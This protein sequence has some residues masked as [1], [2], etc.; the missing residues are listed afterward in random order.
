META[1][2]HWQSL[3]A[4]Q[5]GE[6][7]GET[8]SADELVA[9]PDPALGDFS[10]ACFKLAQ[11]VKKNPAQLAKQ[12]A[13]DFSPAPGLELDR[14]E[15]AG[16]YVNFSISVGD[17]VHRVIRDVEVA[18]NDYGKAPV[19]PKEHALFEYA[20]PNTHK[21]IHIGHLRMIVLG[22]SLLRI[23]RAWGV[24]VTPVS[25]INDV[26]SNVSKCLWYLVKKSG[27]DL[28]A[29]TQ[30]QAKALLAEVAPDDRD[31]RYLGAMYTEATQFVEENPDA[32]EEIS[33]VQQQ[34][35]AHEKAW[36]YLW[37]ETRRWSLE[38]IQSIFKELGVEIDR[39]YFESE[40]LDRGKE[41]VAELMEK[42]IAI[43]SQGAII[44]DLEEQG[45]GAFLIRKTDGTLLYSAKDLAL[46]ELKNE[47][48]PRVKRS[49]LL[50]DSR[51][52]LYFRQLFETLGRIGLPQT[53]EQV[54]F[55]IVTL[56]EGVMSSRKGNVITYESFRDAVV[57][58]AKEEI[59]KRH[60]DWND[61]KVA[62]TA[63]ALAVAGIKFA[64][65][66]QDSDK[67]IVFDMEQALSFDGNTGPYCQYAATRLSSIIRKSG[68]ALDNKRALTRAF[69]H[70]MEKRLAMSIAQFPA[71]LRRA[72]DERKPSH[73]AAWCFETA[74]RI[75]DFYRDVPVLDAPEEI[76][77]GRIRLSAA[78]LS[79]LQKGLDLLGIPL[80]DEM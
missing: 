55:E 58:F 49:L 76:R 45:L 79:V 36:E 16:P 4:G 23:M 60:S 72:V 66:R 19:A 25:Y 14:V 42:G 33:F 15:A 57:D 12:I 78:V 75:S 22:V 35:E 59:I 26:G 53:F 8:V 3:I 6:Q 31:A 54:G 37:Q 34:L 17:A 1:W 39:Q 40:I 62:H 20:N 29:L 28:R 73:V 68:S 30:K 52:S 65:L 27:S 50:V 61:G 13:K 7:L 5:L 47:E 38:E 44:V 41:I 46:A 69:E 18:R 51:Q 43:E 2:T 77:E 11:T 70:P 21:E 56:K 24:P 32:K 67:K 64:M 74:Q 63:W 9:P 48:Y 80:P 71:A 10:F